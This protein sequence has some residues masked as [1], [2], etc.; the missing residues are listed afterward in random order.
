MSNVFCVTSYEYMNYQAMQYYY[1]QSL[2]FVHP[3]E[4]SK[5]QSTVSL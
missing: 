4:V 3:Y 1:V 5:V 2:N